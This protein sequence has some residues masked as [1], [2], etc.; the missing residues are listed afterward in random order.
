MV[1][2]VS[3]TFIAGAFHTV[4]HA[5]RTRRGRILTKVVEFNGTRRPKYRLDVDFHGRRGWVYV[6]ETVWH[7]ANVGDIID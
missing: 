7:F 3:I 5:P 4:F 1:A 2:A 6:T